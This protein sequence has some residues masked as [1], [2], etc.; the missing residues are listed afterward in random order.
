MSDRQRRTDRLQRL[1]RFKQGVSP[2][3]SDRVE[4][5]LTQLMLQFQTGREPQ[6]V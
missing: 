6:Y 2:S 5:K 1:R 4:A 3:M